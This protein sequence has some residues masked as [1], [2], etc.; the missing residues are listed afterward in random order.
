[1][2]VNRTWVLA[3]HLAAICWWFV[4]VLKT[5]SKRLQ[6]HLFRFVRFIRLAFLHP[7]CCLIIPLLLLI[8]LTAWLY[9]PNNYD[10]LTYHMARVAHW[11]QNG[12]VAYYPTPIERQNVMGPGAEY[13]ILFFQLLSGTDHLASFVQYIS[14]GILIFSCFYLI[15][16]VKIPKRLSSYIIILSA[17]AP[18]AVMEASNTKN[19]LVASVMV[20]AIL[21]AAARLFT[22]RMA[23][24]SRADYTLAG[25]AL[26][27]GF[28]VKA[29]SLLV[30][31]PILVA[32][33]C[34]QLPVLLRNWGNLRNCI[35]GSLIAGLAFC[36]I[37]GPD[38]VRKSEQHVSR[39]EVYPLFSQFDVERLWNPVRVL[40]HNIPF[41]EQ[42]KSI[43]S[44]IGAKGD[45]I[46]KD[47]Y[48]L[49][50]DMVGNPYQV[51]A[52]LVLSA[53]TLLLSFLSLSTSY[54]RK[55]L[56]LA[57]TPV[58]SW[59]FFG[60]VVKDQGWI[61]RLEIPL[62]FVLPFSFV[63]LAAL[64][65]QYR[66]VGILLYA[67]TVAASY[68]SLAYA[69]FVAANVP[70]RPLVLSHFWGEKPGW[71]AAYYHNANLKDE[72]DFFLKTVAA[73]NCRRIGLILGPDSADY[74]LTWRAM[75]RGIQV[76][77]VWEQIVGSVPLTFRKLETEF[78]QACMLYVASG[79][80]E[81]V[82]GKGEQWLATGEYH[83][84]IRNSEWDFNN[85]E[86]TCLRIDARDGN[87]RLHAQNDVHIET[88]AEA[89]V[90][91]ATGNDSQVILPVPG[92]CFAKLVVIKLE[93]LS[94]EN[95]DVQFFY[96]TKE[97]NTYSEQSSVSRMIAKGD[98][99]VYVSLSSDDIARPLRIDIGKK[100]GRYEV[101]S[102]E[103]RGVQT[104]V[105]K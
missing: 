50:E 79:S 31:F 25:I 93:V 40:V 53:S 64:G 14:Y 103:I 35:L 9:P 44:K 67:G 45:L 78:D 3:V 101:T 19:D 39:H 43:L 82:P 57:L 36:S 8:G 63:F 96:Q 87:D 74:P 90:L 30:V 13:L 54:Y 10:S 47:V 89:I 32:V 46:T 38:I 22:G 33:L 61:T 1:M 29:T 71:E 65:K 15:R 97:M 99:T 88:D 94:P 100:K 11:I 92:Q 2:A 12:S 85:S 76:K 105:G 75:Q 52:F 83:T 6:A 21:I 56:L 41:P 20:Y 80:I 102:L 34:C 4:W 81:H 55:R 95:T 104:V 26:A 86:Q 5:D 18:I 42:T 48:N 59:M 60:L 17:T 49:H 16:I 58:A 91:M 7:G 98:N 27:G 51:A 28:L 23:R 84:F 37:A 24:M 70:A 77:H 69:F 72:H 73:N 62:F 66:L 68:I